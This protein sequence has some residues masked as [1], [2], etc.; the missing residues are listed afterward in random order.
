[1]QVPVTRPPLRGT[2][3]SAIGI[4][5][6]LGLALALIPCLAPLALV[7]AALAMHFSLAR[8]RHPQYQRAAKR[9]RIAL[10][11]FGAGLAA[12]AITAY[13]VTMMGMGMSM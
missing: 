4:L 2:T 7:H 13:M 5:S 11:G 9:D 6:G 3:G 8:G 12:V 10:L 1:M